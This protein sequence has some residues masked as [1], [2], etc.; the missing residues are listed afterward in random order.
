MVTSM[1]VMTEE[2]IEMFERYQQEVK[3]KISPFLNPE[4]KEWLLNEI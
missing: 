4:E 3:E 1:S 2:D